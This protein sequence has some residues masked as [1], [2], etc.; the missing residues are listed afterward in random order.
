M[1][2]SNWAVI[3]LLLAV[4]IAAAVWAD[5]GSWLNAVATGAC[6]ACPAPPQ[7]SGNYSGHYAGPTS[8]YGRARGVLPSIDGC[9]PAWWKRHS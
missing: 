7:C 9:G 4:G 3:L 1:S 2:N 6:N 5:K 8:R